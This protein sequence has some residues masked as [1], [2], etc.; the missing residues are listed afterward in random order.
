MVELNQNAT[1]KVIP[2][3]MVTS[4]NHIDGAPCPYGTG[5]APTV[6]IS[7]NGGAFASC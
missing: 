1:D 6:E 4:A 3:L 2:F 7:K 5:L